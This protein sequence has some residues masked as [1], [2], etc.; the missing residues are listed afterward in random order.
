MPIILRFAV[1]AG[2]SIAAL[3]AP[4]FASPDDGYLS[5]TY[6]AGRTAGRL[7]DIDAASGYVENALKGDP[8]NIVLVERLFL[9]DV[10]SGDIAAAEELAAR[11]ITFNSEHRMARLVL[12]LADIRNGKFEAARGHFAE[13]AYTPIGELAAA[14]LTAWTYAGEKNLAGAIKELGKLADNES[15]TDFKLFHEGLIADYLNS[16]LRADTAYHAA[17]KNAGSNLRVAQALGSFLHRNGKGKDAERVYRAFLEINA[18]NVIMEAALADLLAKKPAVPFVG[19]VRDG[20]GE[21]LFSLAAA[22]NDGESLEVALV[23]A[24]LA[25]QNSDDAPVM[26]TLLGDVH[27]DM[28]RYQAAIDAYEKVDGTS[29]L[30]PTAETEVALNLQRLKQTDAAQARLRALIAKNANNYSAHVTL[31]NVLR[32]NDQFAEASESYSKAIAL[33]GEAQKPSWQIH[34]FRGI[35]RERLKQWE[36]AEQDFRAALA[37][38][39]EE[40]SVLNYL[41]YSLIDR[42][43]KLD[44]A[45][46]MVKLAVELRPNDGYIIDS[47]GWAFFRLGKFE[48]AVEQ[49]ERAVELKAGDPIIA[50]HL[51][52]AYWKVGRELEARFQWQHAKDNEPEPDDLKRIENKLRNGFV[53]N[54]AEKVEPSKG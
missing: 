23:Y 36:T 41:G 19:S 15:F 42:G 13:S 4:A 27:A 39:P 52:D 38:S 50:E 28:G 5:G 35:A 51:G 54:A 17:S 7:R 30:R 53:E 16:P 47:L 21:A 34:Y 18:N 11:V 22:M 44:E 24:Q 6:L 26:Q 2:L 32:N 9:L 43:L 25:A 46:K 40:A 48:D 8:D 1:A 45:L 37:L 3:S 49:L 12:G 20:V 10:S 33:F 31:G 14:L 29:A